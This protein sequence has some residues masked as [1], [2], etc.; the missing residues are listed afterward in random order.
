[1]AAGTGL[2]TTTSSN[3]GI[4]AS[5]LGNNSFTSTSSFTFSDLHTQSASATGS[6]SQSVT[7]AGSFAGSSYTF[8]TASLSQSANVSWSLTGGDSST[9]SGTDTVLS[10]SHSAGSG[11]TAYGGGTFT[12]LSNGTVTETATDS[13]S[14]R[15]QDS[16]SQ[17]G[18]DSA[19]L[20]EQGSYRALSF[21]FG[22]VVYQDTGS[23]SGTFQ[24]AYTSTF[25]GTSTGSITGSGNQTTNGTFGLTAASALDSSLSSVLETFTQAGTVTGSDS[26]TT[27]D[28]WSLSEQGRFGTGSWSLGSVTYQESFTSHAS[29]QRSEAAAD[30]GTDS[31]SSGATYN[32]GGTLLYGGGTVSGLATTNS[33]AS[34]TDSVT[35]SSA[36]TV[37]QSGTS[38]WSLTEQGTFGGLSFAF[39]SVVYQ[40]GQHSGQTL[41]AADTHG[42]NGNENDTVTLNNSGGLNAPGGGLG[43]NAVLQTTTSALTRAGSDVFSQ[44]IS[45]TDT[46]TFYESGS[47]AGGSASFGSLTSAETYSAGYSFQGGDTQTST[48]LQCLTVAGSDNG[49][50]LVNANIASTAFG[51]SDTLTGQAA[52]THTDTYSGSGTD[53]WSLQE[54]GS[55]ANFS[56]SFGSVVYQDAGSVS[57]SETTSATDCFTGTGIDSRTASDS[58][59]AQD[60]SGVAANGSLGCLSETG[61]VL[62]VQ[63]SIDTLSNNVSSSDSWNLYQAG[64]EAGN[65]Y[66]FTSVAYSEGAADTWSGQALASA[67]AHGQQTSTANGTLTNSASVAAGI[68]WLPDSG[69]ATITSNQTVTGLDTANSAST[70]SDTG[71]D[72]WNR[73]EQGIYASWCYSLSSVVAQGTSTSNGTF[74]QAVPDSFLGTFVLGVHDTQTVTTSTGAALPT[75]SPGQANAN[76]VNTV[77]DTGLLTVADG[78]SAGSSLTDIVSSTVTWYE[79]GSFTGGSFAFSNFSD[80]LAAAHSYTLTGSATSNVTSSLA[81]RLSSNQS[82]SGS[83]AFQSNSAGQQQTAN[84]SAMGPNR[85]HQRVPTR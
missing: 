80:T 51:S 36:Q 20:S 8:G 28:G 68:N 13:Y 21:A 84:Q 56:S 53:T 49:V 77:N 71:S 62:V 2:G 5:V 55:F 7:Q 44:T 59:T 81:G 18:S 9:D 34:G 40:G 23:S 29:S 61:N 54:R 66:S 65:S 6:F 47:W 58:F 30:T 38:S 16:Y 35:D 46:S 39:G 42:F 60:N 64:S 83:G 41:T 67:S 32:S 27:T 82:S 73:S 43:H 19:S 70:I 12:G 14:D 24:Y 31:F 37:T 17:A 1:M 72:S 85:A 78:N 25:A 76:S 79:A 45:S 75:A 3:G 22:S 74:Q 4:S 33:S 69:G 11:T 26:F 63:S 48:G 10:S 52:D 57:K 15:A 50:T